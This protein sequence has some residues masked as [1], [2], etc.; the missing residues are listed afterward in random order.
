MHIPFVQ[1]ELLV[2]S[3]GEVPPHVHLKLVQVSLIPEQPEESKQPK[4]CPLD[5]HLCNEEV[6]DP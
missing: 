5:W 1:E 2:A 6:Q 4:H 3:H